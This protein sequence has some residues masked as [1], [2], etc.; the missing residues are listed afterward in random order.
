MPSSR[1]ASATELE[2][3]SSRI[4]NLTSQVEALSASVTNLSWATK[5]TSCAI[6]T[7]KT[8]L[9]IHLSDLS[10]SYDDALTFMNSVTA[11]FGE[12]SITAG[13]IFDRAGEAYDLQVICLNS[14]TAL[15]K[16]HQATEIEGRRSHLST[17]RQLLEI[18]KILEERN[19]AEQ[20]WDIHCMVN[21]F[22]ENL[23]ATEKRISALYRDTASKSGMQITKLQLRLES[24]PV[25][26]LAA[27]SVDDQNQVGL[28]SI[29]QF[30]C[31]AL[32]TESFDCSQSQKK[33]RILFPISSHLSLMLFHNRMMKASDGFPSPVKLDGQAVPFNS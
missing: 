14:A 29:D 33:V 27:I 9:D 22:L 23:R 1:F 28:N 25:D 4:M 20:L 17:L 5:D 6:S 16:M 19:P 32:Q 10:R 2:I 18:K 30:S 24:L 3:L 11:R 21:R 13:A 31:L 7:F 8:G 15:I 12:L 26:I